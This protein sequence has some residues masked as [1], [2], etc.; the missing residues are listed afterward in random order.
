MAYFLFLNYQKQNVIYVSSKI[1]VAIITIGYIGYIMKKKQSSNEC[2]LWRKKKLSSSLSK[3]KDFTTAE[4]YKI[5]DYNGIR[6]YI[7]DITHKS[8]R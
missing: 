4:Q 8:R 7:M 1:V 2:I 6:T 3:I 5:K